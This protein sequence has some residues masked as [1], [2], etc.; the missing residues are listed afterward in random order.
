VYWKSPHEWGKLIYD[1]ANERALTNSVCTFYEIVSSDNTLGCEFHGLDQIVLKRALQT[2][3]KEGKAAM[4]IVDG[5][6]E[7]VKF[8]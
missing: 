5:K 1:W 2:L 3:E 6:E 7:G 4:I 8:L